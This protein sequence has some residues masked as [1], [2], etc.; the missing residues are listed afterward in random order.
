MD[1]P[2]TATVPAPAVRNPPEDD[3]SGFCCPNPDCKHFQQFGAGN[4]RVCEHMGK[5]K[6]LRRLCCRTCQTRFSELRG[7]LLEYGHLSE[8]KVV[9]AVKCLTWG[10]S[11]EATADICGIDPRS[12]QRIVQR[13]GERADR[14]HRQKVRE[15]ETSQVQMDEVC[16]R[17]GK[18][19][20][21]T[22][23]VGLHGLG[24][25]LQ[26]ALGALRRITGC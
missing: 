26:A 14:F 11:V 4:L 25:V 9:Q 1:R 24:G 13:G 3:L 16:V 18:K 8:E 17:S 12:V 10:N 23:T 6:R 20:A 15:V 22:R 5:D 7:T 21:G 2:T 19:I